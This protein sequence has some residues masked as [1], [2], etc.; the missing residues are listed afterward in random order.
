M[1]SSK[2]SS[3][4][5]G[6]KPK[7][8]TALSLNPRSGRQPSIDMRTI[9]DVSTLSCVEM[10]R[11][12]MRKP[13]VD[14]GKLFSAIA[15]SRNSV[16]KSDAVIVI[17]AAV[18]ETIGNKHA[19]ESMLSKS[20]TV[21]SF[22]KSMRLDDATMR[23]SFVIML[24]AL[25]PEFVKMIESAVKLSIERVQ[26]ITEAPHATEKMVMAAGELM[27]DGSITVNEHSKIISD[28][29][30]LTIDTNVGTVMDPITSPGMDGISANDSASMVGKG[31]VVKDD[32]PL[33]TLGIMRYIK[34][35]PS[36]ARSNFSHEFP[37]V[38]QPVSLQSNRARQGI[39]FKNLESEVSKAESETEF[40]MVMNSLMPTRK[41]TVSGA[42]RRPKLDRSNSS[43]GKWGTTDF[44]ASTDSGNS[45]DFTSA[46][47]S[48]DWNVTM[49]DINA[50]LKESRPKV[51]APSLPIT[52][53]E[54]VEDEDDFL[55]LIK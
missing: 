43:R 33:N 25:S 35:T 31:R 51:V 47:D 13:E 19:A 18:L 49:D 52:T 7:S 29:H 12:I 28:M 17:T 34:N 50:K 2:S 39:G 40:S 46:L 37:M 22:Y 11:Q 6:K 8:A 21:M 32:S 53:I 3:V 16:N 54:S 24:F 4:N 55:N 1:F 15:A 42:T 48:T 9:E 20:R 10:S 26:D 30:S 38:R 23:N 41:V 36:A 14:T 5:E 27:K 44:I 45:N